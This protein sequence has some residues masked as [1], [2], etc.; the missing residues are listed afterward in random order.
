MRTSTLVMGLILIGLLCVMSALWSCSEGLTPS[1][2]AADTPAEHGGIRVYTA[3]DT[4]PPDVGSI[5]LK[6]ENKS[7]SETAFG[8]EYN[9]EILQGDTWYK[10]PFKDVITI[11]DIA[12]IVG[13]GETGELKIDLTL[14]ANKL[15]PGT[16][17]IIKNV[18]GTTL[19]AVFKVETNA[20]GE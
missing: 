3:S 14:L 8:I 13:N 10:L 18:S 19:T 12:M 7:G 4:Y 2:I 1:D 16:Y 20:I 15:S 6:V 17:R 5:T 11:P 9:A